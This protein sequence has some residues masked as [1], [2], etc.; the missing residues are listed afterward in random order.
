MWIVVF[1][2]NPTKVNTGK[3]LFSHFEIICICNRTSYVHC[4]Q[5]LYIGTVLTFKMFS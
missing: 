1:F 4:L 3:H 5:V 2:K